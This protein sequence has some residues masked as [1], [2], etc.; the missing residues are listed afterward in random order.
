MNKVRVFNPSDGPVTVDDSRCIAGGE[1]VELEWTS[2]I[3]SLIASNVLLDKTVVDK[4]P[5]VVDG[6][7]VVP[8]V[9][10]EV[11]DADG[12]PEVAPTET[13]PDTANVKR[14]RSPGKQNVGSPNARD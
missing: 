10:S 12:T 3:Q 1:A 13:Q 14:R 11:K 9:S 6:G 5:V 2:T 4:P 7:G 8:P